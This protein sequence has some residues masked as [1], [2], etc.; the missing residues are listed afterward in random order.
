[1]VSMIALS[2]VDYW[3]KLGQ[4]KPNTI[5]VVQTGSGQTKY[6]TSGSNWVRSNQIL[7]KW[8]KLGQIKPNTIKVV[9]TGSGQTKYYKSGSNWVRSNQIL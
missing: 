9:Q 7:Y 3:F 5:K 4:V 2:A 6:Y 8:F 1:M